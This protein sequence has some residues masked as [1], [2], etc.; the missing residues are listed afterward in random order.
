V[1]GDKPRYPEP[2]LSYLRLLSDDTGVIQHALYGVPNRPTGY[3]TDDN[4]RAL[5]VA[6]QEYERTGCRQA[7]ADAANYLAFLYH[8]L[9]PDNYFHNLMSY[10]RRW[11]DA[12]GS[13]DSH[14][15]ALWAAG[16]VAGS[17]APPEIRRAARQVFEDAVPWARSLRS[18]RAI[19]FSMMGVA[20]YS[21]QWPESPVIAGLPE[22][23]SIQL[24]AAYQRHR[25]DEW[26]W[27]EN[28]LTY[29][30]GMLPHALLRGYE[31]TGNEQCRDVAREALEFLTEILVV[32]GVLQPIGCHGWYARG[33][34]RAWFDQQPVDVMGMVLLYL[35]AA[36]IF[37]DERY[38]E[39]AT[40]SLD[41]FFGRNALGQ[42]MVNPETGACYD[43]LTPEGVNGNQGAESQT[44][45]LLAHLAMV[46][47]GLAPS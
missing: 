16:Y 28:A 41:W 2:N 35:T 26:R 1:K 39:L 10:D 3:T 24:L 33:G 23:L 13:E 44:A 34:T 46:R 9:T 29:S 12:R 11:I 47:A 42:V 37:Q 21:R 15:R 18:L 22:R 20:Y 14:G 25:S 30:N 6:I 45:Y 31:L 38:Q 40:L 36:R 5:L 17:A 4:A 32:D 8:A 43:G 19:A 7:L 27:F